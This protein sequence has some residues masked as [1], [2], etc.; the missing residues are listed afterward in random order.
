MTGT[1]I[2][3]K[4]DPPRIYCLDEDNI[5]HGGTPPDYDKPGKRHGDI[6]VY[7]QTQ[8]RK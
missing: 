5:D 4:S 6:V 2:R 7:L 1:P 3:Y 8:P